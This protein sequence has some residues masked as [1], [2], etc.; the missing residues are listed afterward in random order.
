MDWLCGYLMIP[1][2]LRRSV[3]IIRVSEDALCCMRTFVSVPSKWL[4]SIIQYFVARHKKIRCRIMLF[5]YPFWTAW[6][7]ILKYNGIWPSPTF[8]FSHTTWRWRLFST[9]PANPAT[10]CTTTFV[11]QSC[12][13]RHYCSKQPWIFA[14]CGRVSDLTGS[15]NNSG[16]RRPKQE[17]WSR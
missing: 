9:L 17:L 1:F 2:A 8:I 6:R 16:L 14:F 7:D 10:V 15:N 13:W 12:L 11:T 4:P 3:R 5:N